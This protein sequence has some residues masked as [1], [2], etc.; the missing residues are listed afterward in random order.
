VSRDLFAIDPATHAT[1][2]AQFH[3]K[4]LVRGGVCQAKKGVPLEARVQSMTQ[5]LGGVW[6]EG[7]PLA[8]DVV[9]EYPQVYKHGAA[10]KADPDDVL[11]IAL[12]VGAVIGRLSATYQLVRPAQWKGQVPKKVMNTRVLDRLIASERAVCE[13]GKNDNNLLDAVGLGL[14]VLGRLR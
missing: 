8:R 2:W 10:A 3:D 4:A 7:S 11:A 9:I 13:A 12:V 1:G 6:Y 5:A 14:W